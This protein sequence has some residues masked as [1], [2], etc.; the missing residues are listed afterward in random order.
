[1][2]N[3]KYH[4][5]TYDPAK[6]FDCDNDEFALET[7]ESETQRDELNDKF[8]RTIATKYKSKT[9]T[10]TTAN[11]RSEDETFHY[12]RKLIMS[13]EKNQDRFVDF[14][15][16]LEDEHRLEKCKVASEV[17]DNSMKKMGRLSHL[18]EFANRS[19]GLFLTR[20]GIDRSIK[21]RK[22]AIV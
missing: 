6:S 1:M 5:N 21:A 15:L 4:P 13:N 3:G 11:N 10:K 17:F 7:R 9:W 19:T 8:A 22:N 20:L 14:M 12:F 16:Q 2:S 18:K